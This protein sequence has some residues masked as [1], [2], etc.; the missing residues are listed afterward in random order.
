ML[1]VCCALPFALLLGLLRT[2]AERACMIEGLGVIDSYGRGVAVLQTNL[3]SAL[4]LFV[5][6]II[7][8][9]A[10]AIVFLVPGLILALC[11]LFWPLLWLASGAVAAYFSTL[12]TLAWREWTAAVSAAPVTV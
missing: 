12:W 9:I 5:L 7:I 8:M 3:G 1:L 10:L 2:F 4:V 6:Q 11:F